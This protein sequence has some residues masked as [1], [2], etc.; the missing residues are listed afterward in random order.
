VSSG[1][2]PKP[3]WNAGEK[4]GKPSKQISCAAYVLFTQCQLSG[5]QWPAAAAILE[6]LH[7]QSKSRLCIGRW[8]M[9]PKTHFQRRDIGTSLNIS[10]I[11]Q[12][13]RFWQTLSPQNVQTPHTSSR[14]SISECVVHKCDLLFE[15]MLFYIGSSTPMK[16][17]PDTLQF[18]V[19][20]WIT[21]IQCIRFDGLI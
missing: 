15:F 18:T 4:S 2:E 12:R 19:G 3:R 14:S 13:A 5:R 21:W 16:A 7:M 9:M 20:R 11:T 1:S 8:S 17:H 6:G 10:L